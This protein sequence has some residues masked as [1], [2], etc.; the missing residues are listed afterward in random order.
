MKNGFNV[1]A[2]IITLAFSWGAVTASG[3]GSSATSS[4]CEDICACQ[5]CTTNDFDACREAGDKA[6]DQAD[7]AGCSS[8]FEDLIAC[9]SAKVSCKDDRAVFDGCDAE[10]TALTKCSNTIIGFGKN[11]CELA[12]D[13]VS[14]KIVSCG[15]MQSPSS[16][17][18]GGTPE[19]TAALG[20]QSTCTAAC[21][22]AAD[23]TLLVSDPNK[24]PTAEQSQSFLNCLS[25]CTNK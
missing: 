9:S 6:T 19:C 12:A 5:R 15:G 13:S 4:L 2:A 21:V 1:V 10:R 18:S 3:C 8:Q 20:A 24:P 22:D 17:S 25:A 16:S 23:C 7:A 14:A 11:P